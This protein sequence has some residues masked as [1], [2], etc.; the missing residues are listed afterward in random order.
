MRRYNS[1]KASIVAS[2]AV[3]NLALCYIPGPLLDPF[4]FTRCVPVHCYGSWNFF[5]AICGA[6][7]SKKHVISNA[8]VGVWKKYVLR[9]HDETKHKKIII[10]PTSQSMHLSTKIT[11]LQLQ[12][13]EERRE[14][15]YAKKK[16]LKWDKNMLVLEFLWP[17]IFMVPLQCAGEWY[18]SFYSLHK[19]AECHSTYAL[20]FCA[21]WAPHIC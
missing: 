13:M 3:E 5:K 12:P 16:L 7:A 6:W 2:G 18:S 9:S 15:A 20:F 14:W 8:T 19:S 17:H 1:R 11:G 4:I 10:I 21:W